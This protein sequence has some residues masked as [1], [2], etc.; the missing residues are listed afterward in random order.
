MVV[1]DTVFTRGGR[2]NKDDKKQ[3]VIAVFRYGL[4]APAI[5]MNMEQKR[6]YFRDLSKKE[7]DVPYHGIKRYRAGTLRGWLNRYVR[8]GYDSL[9]PA[10]R[11]DKGIDRRI[12]DETMGIISDIIKEYPK[13]SGSGIYRKLITMGHIRKGDFAEGTLRDCIRRNN[14]RDTEEAKKDRRKFEKANVNEL[15]IA[16]FMHGPRLKQGKK[17]KKVYLC[18][19]IDD[20][21]RMIVGWGWF[22]NE[23]CAAL[24]NTLKSAIAT[25]G[26]PKVFYCDNGKVFHT[27]YLQLICA[28][29]GIALVHSQP[30]DSPSR[31]KIERFFRTVRLKFLAALDT[32][33]I[34]LDEIRSL[35]AEWLEKEYHKAFHTGINSRPIDR[36]FYNTAANII[37]TISS[38]E[39]DN[40][41]MNVI[42]RLVR[43]DAT[44]SIDTKLYEAPPGFIGKKVSL[45]FPID[46]PDKITLLD[47]SS[48]PVCLIKEVNLSE[49]ANKPHTG[50][51][52]RDITEQ[53]DNKNE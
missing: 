7:I 50:I 36:Y 5:H 25:Y 17:K 15:W 52:F 27:N 47:D 8:G 20:H 28:K 51:H 37:K 23:N 11:I 18:A 21:S 41:F 6:E 12:T 26:L 34:S 40:M 42:H 35:F 49:N 44:V 33:T 24:S 9:K 30:Y 10:I 2:M 53:E 3:E 46:R 38:H 19:I 39:L 48:N 32:S 45:S 13:L 4:I 1:Q 43:N 14:L 16:D 29:A 31:G 22:S